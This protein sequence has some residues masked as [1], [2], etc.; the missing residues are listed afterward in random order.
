MDSSQIPPDVFPYLLGLEGFQEAYAFASYL[1]DAHRVLIIGETSGRDYYFQR[2]LGKFVVAIDIVRH[3]HVPNIV[4]SN[5]ERALPL[6]DA[7]FDAVIISEVLEHLHNDFGVLAEIRRVLTDDGALVISVPFWDDEPCHARIHSPRT[8]QLLVECSG[9]KISQFYERGALLGLT[10]PLVLLC[11]LTYHLKRMVQS[12]TKRF[13][14]YFKILKRISDF[15]LSHRLP[16]LWPI[17]KGHGC[18]LVAYK[19]KY[20]DFIEVQE[21]YFRK[22]G[23]NR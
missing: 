18:Y 22:D 12:D 5:A 4:Q 20:R 15:N 13:E 17:S 19:D 1:E 10:K 14:H 6:R 16:R 11:A 9:F 8:I 21:A 23:L 7:S 2:A 3:L